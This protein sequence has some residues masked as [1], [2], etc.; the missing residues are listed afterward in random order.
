M[1]ILPSAMFMQ[2][3]VLQHRTLNL[4]RKGNTYGR[5]T[6]VHLVPRLLLTAAGS[7][8]KTQEDDLSSRSQYAAQ[9]PCNA[10]ANHPLSIRQI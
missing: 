6:S 1:D 2:M 7:I 10:K 9:D 8:A 5:K 4:P 3:L